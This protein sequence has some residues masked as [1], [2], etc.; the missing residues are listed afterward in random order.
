VLAAANTAGSG[1]STMPLALCTTADAVGGRGAFVGR[2]AAPH[3]AGVSTPVK[4][5]AELLGAAAVS[6][7]KV[8]TRE[9][10]RRKILASVLS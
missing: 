10:W 2:N 5:G 6:T 8:S 4:A 9:R 7:T 3:G 1:G